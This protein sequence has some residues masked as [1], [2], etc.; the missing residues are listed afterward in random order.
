MLSSYREFGGESRRQLI[1]T[2]GTLVRQSHI[3][4]VIQL[5]YTV[6]MT[7]VLSYTDILS[8]MYFL[9]NTVTLNMNV[10]IFI[11]IQL[12]IDII[13]PSINIIYYTIYI[14]ITIHS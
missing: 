13:I 3:I 1:V 4:N 14:V 11:V 7:I 12:Y 9:Y 8:M 10:Q 6:T 5:F 2:Y